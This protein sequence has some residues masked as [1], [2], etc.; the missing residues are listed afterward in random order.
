M[1]KAKAS[2]TTRKP[3]VTRLR[4]GARTSKTAAQSRA[5]VEDLLA[6]HGASDFGYRSE[7]GAA[8]ISFTLDNK[9]HEYRLPLPAE[10]EF[11]YYADNRKRPAKDVVALHEQAVRARWRAAVLVVRAR[12]EAFACGIES[13]SD[14]FRPRALLP[15]H[16]TADVDMG[17]VAPELA[18]KPVAVQVRRRMSNRTTLVGRPKGTPPLDAFA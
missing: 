14:A 8:I 10:S 15:Q 12:L 6:R 4:Y 2:Q 13:F 9:P 1:A 17:A 5:E 18:A 3:P 11:Y 7:Q 16:A